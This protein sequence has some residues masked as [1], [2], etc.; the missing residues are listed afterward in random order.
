VPWEPGARFHFSLPGSVQGFE[1]AVEH[2][3]GALAVEGIAVTPT[4]IPSEALAMTGYELQACPTLYSGQVVRVQTEGA[5]CRLLVRVYDGSDELVTLRGPVGASEWRVPDTGGQPI[6][7]VGI[8][9]AGPARLRWLTWEGA[10]NV[11][12][13]RPSDGGSLWRRAWVRGV[14][15]FDAHWPEPFRLVQNRGRGLL[16]QGTREWTDYAVQAAIVPET[17][18]GAGI[19]ARVQG[20]RRYYALLLGADGVAR[21]VRELDGEATL[22]AAPLER[23]DYAEPHS[24]ELRVAGDRLSGIVDGESLLEARDGALACGAVALVCEEG[25]LTC[26][27]VVVGPP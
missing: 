9:A 13:T 16:L 20:L 22:A 10:P 27:A 4:F 21:L 25:C 11:R 15:R 7:Q 2:V 17:I 12:L 24:L 1:G 18:A 5:P 3:D 26:D 14:D 8:E 6:A 19:A 23:R